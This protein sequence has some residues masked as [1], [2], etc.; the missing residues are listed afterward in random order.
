MTYYNSNCPQTLTEASVELTGNLPQFV[1]QWFHMLRLK[2]SIR[3]ERLQLAS[4]SDAQ[5]RDIG[6]D[7]ASADREA[8][9]RD[10]PEARRT[11]FV[12]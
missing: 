9:R 5:L 2:A 4:L 10:L 12:R 3:R 8:A 1:S 6:V 11:R 7:R